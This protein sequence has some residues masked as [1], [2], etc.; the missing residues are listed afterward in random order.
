MV[1]LGADVRWKASQLVT[2]YLDSIGCTNYALGESL[3]VES[4]I[5]TKIAQICFSL[6]NAA[7][8]EM[9]IAS[10]TLDV[11][12]TKLEGDEDGVCGVIIDQIDFEEEHKPTTD[13]ANND[14]DRLEK[15]LR[16]EFANILKTLAKEIARH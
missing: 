9:Q 3:E 14:V 6:K 16:A 10:M 5:D 8:K 7:L 15:K 13:I 4:S 1:S 2:N 12:Y 11:V